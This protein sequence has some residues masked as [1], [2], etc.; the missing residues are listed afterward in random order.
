VRNEHS[1]YVVYPAALFDGWEVLREHAAAGPRFFETR[2]EAVDYAKARAR[3]QQARVKIENWFGH[4]EA[5]W[6]P[7]RRGA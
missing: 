4:T 2:A 6:E 3:T 1:T 5:L 7:P